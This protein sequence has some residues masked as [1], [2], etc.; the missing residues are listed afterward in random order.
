MFR[1][2]RVRSIMKR[3]ICIKC[4]NLF[5][6]PQSLWNHKKRCLGVRKEASSVH[7]GALLGKGVSRFAVPE[8]KHVQK[9]S[10]NESSENEDEENVADDDEDIHILDSDDDNEDDDGDDEDEADDS[11]EVGDSDEDAMVERE[12]ETYHDFWRQFVMVTFIKTI[13]EVLES[14]WKL[15]RIYIATKKDT[16]FQTIM[17][18]TGKLVTEKGITF[19]KALA[20]AVKK[21]EH[22][23]NCDTDDNGDLWCRLRALF[24]QRDFKVECICYVDGV[25]PCDECDCVSM[26]EKFIAFATLIH[27]MDNDTLVQAIYSVSGTDVSEAKLLLLRARFLPKVLSKYDKVKESVKE[28]AELISESPMMMTLLKRNREI[29]DVVM[30]CKRT[31]GDGLWLRPYG[32]VLP[33]DRN[34]LKKL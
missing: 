32:D 18:E 1:Q 29:Y 13:D 11:D 26:L 22:D 20:V 9:S 19:E 23:L 25:C 34:Y 5:A 6:S 3:H 21:H 2:E 15:F 30:K 14:F 12:D 7:Q 24:E 27:R 8:S 28:N 17:E 31:G 4:C 16:L 33:R 10:S